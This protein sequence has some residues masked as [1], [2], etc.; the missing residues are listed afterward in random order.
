MCV[1]FHIRFKS[2]KQL[3]AVWYFVLTTLKF[4]LLIN[5][6]VCLFDFI[7]LVGWKKIAFGTIFLSKI[8]LYPKFNDLLIELRSSWVVQIGK[9][10]HLA[11]NWPHKII[12]PIFSLT[13]YWN[14]LLDFNLTSNKKKNNEIEQQHINEKF[15]R[16]NTHGWNR[17]GSKTNR[18]KKVLSR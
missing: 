6:F 1:P 4:K 3:L 18:N 7:V 2:A 12:K 9:K 15:G 14:R 16:K 17:V 5:L 13:S 11:R 10:E 8:I